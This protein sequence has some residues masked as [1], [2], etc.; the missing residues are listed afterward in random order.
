MGKQSLLCTA[1]AITAPK[2]A[3]QR[4]PTDIFPG[5]KNQFNCHSIYYSSF[6]HTF[7]TSPLFGS[8]DNKYPAVMLLV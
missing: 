7:L 1:E 2:C 4:K 3:M 8:L 6:Y 5:T